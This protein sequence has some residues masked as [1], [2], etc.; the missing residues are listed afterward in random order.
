VRQERSNR[1]DQPLV[2]CLSDPFGYVLSLIELPHLDVFRNKVRV[3]PD[4]V[5]SKSLIPLFIEVAENKEDLPIANW[6]RME[7]IHGLIPSRHFCTRN[8]S[9]FRPRMGLA[10][11]EDLLTDVAEIKDV[12]FRSIDAD[13]NRHPGSEMYTEA[14]EA[15]LCSILEVAPYLSV[16]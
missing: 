10:L 15:C 14:R 16:A 4:V 13:F 1:P 12:R 5:L 2:R 11:D 6:R 3:C 8:I 9:A 7:V